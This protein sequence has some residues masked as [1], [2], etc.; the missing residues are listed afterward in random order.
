M[1]TTDHERSRT[2]DGERFADTVS[3]DFCDGERDL[4]GLVWITRLPNAAVTRADAVV[5]ARGELVERIERRQDNASESWQPAR[6]DGISMSTVEPLER[7][8]LE[9]SGAA[10]SLSLDAVQLSAPVELGAAIADSIGVFQYEQLCKLSGMVTIGEQAHPVTCTGRRVH[11]W[12][13]FAWDGIERWRTLYAAS[14]T[15]RAISAAAA[16]PAGGSGHGDELRAASLIADE[17]IQPFEDVRISTV[18]TDAGLPAKAGLELGMPG[19][20][21]PQ[22]MGGEAICT[23]RAERDDHFVTLSFFRWSL[24]GVPACGL[25]EVLER[26]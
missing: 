26:R 8:S 3:V 7:W 17:E 12:G 9:V 14:E 18:W 11:A 21:I 20:E 22:R 4:F 10:A 6:V 13:E 19:D 24:E 5:F 25:Y 1:I 2:G 23:T 16:L 15:G